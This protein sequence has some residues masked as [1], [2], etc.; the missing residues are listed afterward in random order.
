M[1][2]TAKA[3]K[4][5][6]RG[7]SHERF[8]SDASTLV[9]SDGLYLMHEKVVHCQHTWGKVRSYYSWYSLSIVISCYGQLVGGSIVDAQS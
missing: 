7:V 3:A 5:G 4:K 1:L 6:E 8:Y 2:Q 9:P